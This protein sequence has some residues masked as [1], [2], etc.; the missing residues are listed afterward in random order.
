MTFAIQPCWPKK[1]QPW[2][3]FR[4]D[5][6]NSALAP[7]MLRMITPLPG[8]RSIHQ[9][10]VNRD[11]AVRQKNVEHTIK[12]AELAYAMGIPTMRVNTGR[13]GTITD[14][15]ELMKNRGIEPDFPH[16]PTLSDARAGF[17]Q[18]LAERLEAVVGT[19]SRIA[20]GLPVG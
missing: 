20:R 3:C 11:P 17:V 15:D 18:A 4:T 7:A 2:I 19:V 6:W 1:Q 9:G 16:A 13:W 12:C 10:F 8:F 5:G 14:F